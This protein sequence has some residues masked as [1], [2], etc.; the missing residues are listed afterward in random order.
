MT[1]RVRVTKHA[2]KPTKP[3][4]KAKPV[5]DG[6][7]AVSLKSWSDLFEYVRALT[8]PFSAYVWRG[9]RDARW[10][11]TSTLERELRRSPMTP[12]VAEQIARNHRLAF[13]QAIR[14][15]RGPSPPRL[16]GESEVWALGQHHGLKTPLLDWTQSPFV[17]LYFAFQEPC[18]R[19][20]VEEHVV[21]A[22]WGGDKFSGG[23]VPGIA[24]IE[25]VRPLQD[26]NARLVS[27]S[28]LFTK[29]PIGTSVDDHVQ[30]RLEGNSTHMGLVKISIPNGGRIECL[31][32]LHRMNINH[33]SL[34]PDLLGSSV[35][36]N[37]LLEADEY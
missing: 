28:G 18:A 16:S 37:W 8:L 25:F 12:D 24:G 35:H 19:S 20:E 7:R 26:E 32:T 36:C 17:A 6:L 34:F 27:Q 2:V 4:W 14:G 5:K 1:K 33:L 21:W 31:K 3:P 9:Q 30:L 11:L 23:P 29:I 15:C 13:E 10:P 22:L